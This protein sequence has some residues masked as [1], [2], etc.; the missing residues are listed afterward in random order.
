MSAKKEVAAIQASTERIKAVTAEIKAITRPAPG[1]GVLVLDVGTKTGFAWASG[2][3]FGH[4]T[5]DFKRAKWQHHGHQF[6]AMTRWLAGDLIPKIPGG[7]Q[8]ISFELVG[9][10]E[11][12]ASQMMGNGWRACCLMVCAKYGYAYHETVPGTW[13]KFTIGKGNAKK[14]EIVAWVE[15]KLHLG[16]TSEDE[17]DAVALLCYTLEHHYGVSLSAF[18]RR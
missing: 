6:R 10:G 4:G 9:F 16:I 3:E 1:T 2:T 17:A 12:Q 14:P 13:K 11:G 8:A 7:I 15:R 18:E 5:K